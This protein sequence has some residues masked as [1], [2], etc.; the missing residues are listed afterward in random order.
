MTTL[1]RLF[2]SPKGALRGIALLLIAFL[3]MGV[4][5]VVVKLLSGDYAALQIVVIRTLI[6]IP[7]VLFIWLRQGTWSELGQAD[8]RV[9]F[10]RG[11][12]MFSAYIFFFLALAALPYSLMLG[13]FFSGPLFITALSVP[14]LGETVGWQRWL[15]VLIGFCGVLIIIEPWG[16]DFEPATLLAVAAAVAYA[17]SMIFTRRLNDSPQIITVYTT[18]V[19]LIGGLLLSPLFAALPQI[20]RFEATHPSLRFMT[21]AWTMPT[22]TDFGLIAL[23][24][25][26]WGVGMV[27]LSA[28]Y[29]DT[30]VA[31]LAPFEY[32]SIIYGFMYGYIFWREIPTPNMLI[33]MALI[34][35]CGIFIIYRENSTSS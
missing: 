9:E 2:S 29:R 28:A 35:G 19:Y 33:G 12:W 23:I 7:I 26:C 5:D 8:F 6:S 4:V 18:G 11:F 20:F 17:L 1:T 24:A 30:E 14:M 27:L 25:L 3:I 22:V 15:A 31:I 16:S 21:Q 10:W 32:F 13:I 34:I